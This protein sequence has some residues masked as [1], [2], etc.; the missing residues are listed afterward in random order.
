ML[1][2]QSTLFDWFMRILRRFILKPCT[3]LYIFI[4]GGRVPYWWPRE[5]KTCLL[6]VNASDGKT[7]ITDPYQAG[8]LIWGSSK[9]WGAKPIYTLDISTA[10]SYINCFYSGRISGCCFDFA[11]T[12]RQWSGKISFTALLIEAVWQECCWRVPDW[13]GLGLERQ[14]QS[15]WL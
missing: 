1:W 14:H 4:F 9:Y 8:A 3:D 10:V 12:D 15:G 6:Q 7:K 5:C 2:A 11:V 13:N